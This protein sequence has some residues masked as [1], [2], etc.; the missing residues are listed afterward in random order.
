MQTPKEN[1]FLG[2]KP[3]ELIDRQKLYGRDKD[4]FLMKDR[5]FSSRTTLLFA[6]SGVGK[7]SFINAKI[8][9]ELEGQYHI[10]YH[11]Q[12]A[13]GDPLHAL[14]KSITANPLPAAPSPSPA[15]SPGRNGQMVLLDHLNGFMK[16]ES[17]DAENSTQRKRCLIILDQFEEV[18]QHHS[19]EEYF[20]RFI[21]ELSELINFNSCNSRVLFSMREEF[22][23]ELSVFDNKIPDLFNNYYRL[24]CPTR[25][26]AEDI[27]RRTC[28]LEDVS[29]GAENLKLLVSDLARVEKAKGVSGDDSVADE[30]FVERNIVPPPYLQIACQS[31]WDKQFASNNGSATGD[32]NDREQDTFLATYQT[33]DARHML[34]L[35]CHQ[36]LASLDKRERALVAEAFDYLVT[37]RGAKMAYELSSLAEHMQ[38]DEAFLKSVLVKLSQP[39]SM[40]LRQTNAPNRAIWFE[41]YHDMYGSIID[42]WKRGYRNETNARLRR[43]L[44][45]TATYVLVLA[46]AALLVWA[47][48]HW[49]NKPRQYQEALRAAN[50]RDQTSFRDGEMAFEALRET[51]GYRYRAKRLWADAWQ[52]RANLA[53]KQ[54]NGQEAFLS[55]LTA[56][57]EGP[58]EQESALLVQAGPYL[59]DDGFGSLLG[60][61]RL[62]GDASSPA[63]TPIFSADGKT[64]LSLTTDLKVSQWDTRSNELLREPSLVLD[65]NPGPPGP[66]RQ[67]GPPGPTSAPPGG[68][69]GNKR[70]ALATPDQEP[71]PGTRI[72][73][74]GGNRLGGLNDG[75]FFIWRADGTKFWTSDPNGRAY[76]PKLPQ[77]GSV[78]HRIGIPYGF[79]G[80][81]ISFTP[82]GQYFAT[83]DQQGSVRAYNINNE[84]VVPIGEQIS[85]AV[86][87]AFSPDNHTLLVFFASKAVQVI[88]LKQPGKSRTL[89]VQFN[90]DRRATFSPDG[91]RFLAVWQELDKVEVGIWDIA[92]GKRVGIING[93]AS[94]ATSL[95]FCADN[96][97]VALSDVVSIAENKKALITKFWDSDSKSVSVTRTTPLEGNETNVVNP[98]GTSILTMAD[99][100]VARLW[101]FGPPE[102]G[103]KI[104][105]DSSSPIEQSVMSNNGHVVA[106]MNEEGTV[107]NWETDKPSQIGQPITVGN[108]GSVAVDV[109]RSASPAFRRRVGTSSQ[110]TYCF[111]KSGSG[112]FDI[113]DIKNHRRVLSDRVESNNFFLPVLFSAN[114]EILAVA[115]STN[116]ITLWQNLGRAPT[117]GKITLPEI[118]ALYA[119][120]FAP[121]GK[122]LAVTYRDKNFSTTVKIFSVATGEEVR[123]FGGQLSLSNALGRDVV[124]GRN[125][126]LGRN[127]KIIANMGN[128]NA[129]QVMDI[130]TGNSLQLPHSSNVSALSLNRNGTYALTSTSDGTLQLW[131]TNSGKAIANEKY[132]TRFRFL[133]FSDDGKSAFALSDNWLHVFSITKT[134]MEY[135]DG[136]PIR[137]GGLPRA[138][139]ETGRNLRRIFQVSPNSLEVE[140]IS[141]IPGSTPP[142]PAESAR[143]LLNTWTKKLSLKFD[144]RGQ[145][146]QARGE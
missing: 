23:G 36:N 80:P 34:K 128:E 86:Q 100:N 38:V 62:K 44:E 123:S 29:A 40:I 52:R 103:R 31:L 4:L 136:R 85:S 84:K 25:E 13:I 58:A 48:D 37:K 88:D 90:P 102:P 57:A 12:W 77:N 105:K 70:R 120:V 17:A 93:L 68:S 63:Y 91:S 10:V 21:D 65:D 8:R 59:S 99:G 14:V 81:S 26:E 39:E 50:L 139:D 89:K 121:D 76:G 53:E 11:N 141:F 95:N 47:A 69:P 20:A 101:R 125:L 97:T 55:W 15:P 5:I 49:W 19:N 118:G 107:M 41:L 132:V 33:G 16:P 43:V 142:V 114:E 98:D 124:F 78:G 18:F 73:A 144:D 9:P 140:D 146:T 130:V 116:V 111:I 126:A 7:T 122:Y 51:W 72:Q 28:N 42:D 117:S 67:P 56:A 79:Q 109:S 83:L 108:S 92:K 45:K 96:K 115:N 6:G 30:G 66:P 145:L 82:D 87:V 135:Y 106:T 134:G 137:V 71:F 22:L 32:T 138:I 94:A 64:L 54:E 61:F 143:D 127:A 133:R 119:F 113:W 75:R 104:I 1:P 129:V 46:F 3:Y 131:D 60:S 110:G 35:F 112:Q 74:A 2:L 24:K 27:I